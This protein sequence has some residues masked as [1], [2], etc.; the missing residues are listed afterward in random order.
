MTA[1]KKTI[2]INEDILKEASTINPN[3][4]SVVEMALIEYLHH[5]RIHKAAESFGKWKNRKESSVDF[6]NNL[7]KKDN[8]DEK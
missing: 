2:S 6:V 8:R 5:Y 3:F 7:R 4:S 1:V